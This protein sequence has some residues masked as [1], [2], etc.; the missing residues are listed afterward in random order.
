MFLAKQHFIIT[1]PMLTTLHMYTN[2][3]DRGTKREKRQSND[4][5]DASTYIYH[6][7]FL[8]GLVQYGYFFMSA[9]STTK[10]PSTTF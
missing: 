1:F 6:N 9:Y 10:T 3:P 2:T 5:M 7:N 4:S 8:V